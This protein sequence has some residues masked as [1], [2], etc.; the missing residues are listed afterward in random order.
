MQLETLISIAYITKRTLIVPSK[1]IVDH[2]DNQNI[3]E[4]DVFDWDSLSSLICLTRD[5]PDIKKYI[6]P[7]T[8]DS[9]KSIDEST[10]DEYKNEKYWYFEDLPLPMFHT[11]FTLFPTIFFTSITHFFHTF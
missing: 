3:D 8:Q 6:I 10:L 9:H 11:F 4:F 1:S 5:E 7:I 2:L